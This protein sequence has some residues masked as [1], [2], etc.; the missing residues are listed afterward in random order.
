MPDILPLTS[1]AIADYQNHLSQHPT[2][3]QVILDY[4]TRHIN[5]LMCAEIEQVVTGLIRDRLAI[6]CRDEVTANYLKSLR[7]SAIR[8][9]T[10]SEI[11]RTLALFGNDYRENFDVNARKTLA[12]SDI[13][14]LGI[15]VKNRDAD[16][17]EAPPPI[18]FGELEDAYNVATQVVD[19]VRQ[20][21]EI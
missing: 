6:G 4:L 2:T 20:T 18:T 17:H 12:D 15:A 19:A 1:A 7:R 13:E 3:D 5:G 8:N 21:L 16:A 11:G 10:F 9:A 14:K